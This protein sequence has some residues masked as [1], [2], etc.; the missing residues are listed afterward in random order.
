MGHRRHI[1]VCAGGAGVVARRILALRRRL[2]RRADSRPRTFAWIGGGPR[3]V[4][5]DK[6][7][8]GWYFTR[9][10]VLTFQQDLPKGNVL[11]KGKWWHEPLASPVPRVSVEEEAARRL[12]LD[13]GSTIEFDIQGAKITGRVS[14]I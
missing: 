4:D 1:G 9:E 7:E 13:L 10:Y 12:G 5:Y 3:P 8:H 11:L 14:N 6:R 2:H